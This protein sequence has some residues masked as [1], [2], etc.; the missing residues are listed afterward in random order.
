MRDSFY[1]YDSEKLS[2][3]IEF[4]WKGVKNPQRQ[5]FITKK[6]GKLL[7]APNPQ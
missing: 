7:V 2:G 3:E 5:S 4:D 6:G 1:A